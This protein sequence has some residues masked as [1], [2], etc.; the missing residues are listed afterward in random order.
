MVCFTHALKAV[1]PYV[2]GSDCFLQGFLKGSAN[3]HDFSCGFHLCADGS[4]AVTEFVK[5]P[6]WYFHDDVV[7]AWLKGGGGG[8]CYRVG[9]FI[10]V[11]S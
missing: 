10:E 1:S 4:I 5:R 8:F 7:D 3:G 2:K 6:S 9:Y 11:F